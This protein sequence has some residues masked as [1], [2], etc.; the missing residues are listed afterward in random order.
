MDSTLSVPKIVFLHDQAAY[1]LVSGIPLTF[2]RSHQSPVDHAQ[3]V[4]LAHREMAPHHCQISFDGHQVV[5]A[6][7][8]AELPCYVNGQIISQAVIIDHG[9]VVTFGPF[10]IELDSP[11]KSIEGLPESEPQPMAS[12]VGAISLE[13]GLTIGCGA[14]CVVRLESE[15]FADYPDGTLQVLIQ[16]NEDGFHIT[17]QGSEPA[18]LNGQLFSAENLIIGDYLQIGTQSLRFDGRSLVGVERVLGGQLDAVQISKAYGDTQVLHETSFQAPP[19]GFIGI[20]GPSGHG[21]TTLLKV[22]SGIERPQSGQVLV[23]GMDLFDSLDYNRSL[24]GYVPQDDIV[25][26]ELTVWDALTYS[27]YLRL[28]DWTSPREVD[29]LI[30][31]IL[32][33]LGLYRPDKGIDHSHKRL[34][35]LSGGQRKRV[36]VAVELLNR[37]QI[38]FLDEP[39]SGLDP[40]MEFELMSTLRSLTQSGCTVICTTHV[41]ENVFLMDSVAVIFQGRRVFQGDSARARVHFEVDR[42]SEVYTRLDEGRDRWIK[43]AY[44]PPEGI[45]P[46]ERPVQDLVTAYKKSTP[47][48]IRHLL[49]RHWAILRSDPKNLLLL[50]GQ[51]IIIGLLITLAAVTEGAVVTK[52][53][54]AHVTTF[55]FG[56]SNAAQEVVKERPIF[57]REKFVGLSVN[58][59]LLGK[60]FALG[61][62]ACL[63][64]LILF[65]VLFI[66]VHGLNEP[67]RGDLGWQ[68]TALILSALTATGIGLALSSWAKR[69]AQAVLAVP[70]IIIPQ[71]LL[72]GYVF[73]LE[74]WRPEVKKEGQPAIQR[75]IAVLSAATPSGSAQKIMDTSYFWN[76]PAS[77]SGPI[78][79]NIPYENL[80][81][82]AW[83]ENNNIS[84]PVY[85]DASGAKSGIAVLLL[86]SM[87]SYAFAWVHLRRT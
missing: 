51:P 85:N 53:F 27:A 74:I 44:P 24:M 77:N 48:A 65:G 82:A 9:C 67:V 64:A 23:N 62:I 22:I 30:A 17:D 39:T 81:I 72:A 28:P 3:H 84:S 79:E 35:E 41:L 52:L 20:L 16:K 21:K 60:V 18:W 37:P 4:R 71:I 59:Y 33:D 12:V 73:P 63:Q 57:T 26:G 58:A 78:N 68:L 6:P 36:S 43:A 54:L 49:S 70:L 55:W 66:N 87:I 45:R 75:V 86:W 10:N 31:R 15:E 29:K 42:L 47:R 34:T 13:D 2:G 50:F 7:L 61:S 14:S 5:F 25:H 19:G 32:H 38:L 46:Q 11:G 80:K 56:C 1:P 76:R 69:Q 8:Q 83:K 40:G